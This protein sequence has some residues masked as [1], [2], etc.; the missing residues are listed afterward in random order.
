MESFGV[1]ASEFEMFFVSSFGFDASEFERFFVS[2]IQNDHIY[3]FP[4]DLK[5]EHVLK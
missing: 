5:V 3:N 4:I 1:E 2:S